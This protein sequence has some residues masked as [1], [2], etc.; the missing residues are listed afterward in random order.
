MTVDSGRAGG[1]E[2]ERYR[3]PRYLAERGEGASRGRDLDREGWVST[4]RIG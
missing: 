4:S 3:M 2:K 1:L